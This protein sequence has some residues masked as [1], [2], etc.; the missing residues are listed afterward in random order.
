MN[1]QN[2]NINP[3]LNNVNGHEEVLIVDIG[4]SRIWNEIAAVRPKF[5]SLLYMLT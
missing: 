1:I 2:I 3:I 5:T 4:C